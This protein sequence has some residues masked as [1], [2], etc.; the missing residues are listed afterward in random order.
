[1]P[2][3]RPTKYAKDILTKT[4]DYI[5]TCGNEFWEF[6]KGHGPTNTFERR[7]TVRLPSVEGL[8]L[9]L[10]VNRSTIYEWRD[11]HPEF[12]NTLEEIDLLQKKMLIECGLSNDYN[13]TIVKLMLSSNHG[14]SEKT[15]ITSKGEAL[16][17]VTQ[18]AEEDRDKY[19]S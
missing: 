14:M 15:D 5:D 4:K 17:S 3:G 13:P 12:S 9:H 11:K 7:V 8:A 19:S 18:T 10:G 6:Q 1:M 2:A 16:A